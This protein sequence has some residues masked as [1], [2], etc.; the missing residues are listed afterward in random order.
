LNGQQLSEAEFNARTKATTS[1]DGKEVEIDGTLR[2]EDG[3]KYIVEKTE[4]GTFWHN[5]KGELHRVD[6]P[7]CEYA[8]GTKCW[9][10]NGQLHR[11]DGPAIERA[12]GDKEWWL[13]GRLH[14]VNGPA[15]EHVNGVKEWWLNGKRHRV[16]GPAIEWADS[17]PNEWYLNGQELSEA[18]FNARTK[19]TTSL[20]DK[21][22]D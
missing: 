18:E 7:A 17:G 1:L 15:I 2:F 6:G 12:N 14:R 20:N 13:N 19:V 3:M 16:D 8:S 4:K 11:V 10:L 21:E 9:Y 5:E 22:V